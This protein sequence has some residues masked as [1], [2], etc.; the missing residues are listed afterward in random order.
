LFHHQLKINPM[1]TFGVIL[2]CMLSFSTLWGQEKGLIGTWNITSW[3]N[4]GNAGNAKMTEEQLKA[5]NQVTIYYFMEE[6]KFKQTSNMAGSGSNDTYEGTWKTSGKNLVINLSIG[7]QNYDI[8][9]TYE[10][11][12]DI[13]ILTRVS[14]DN[15]MKIINTFR[16][17]Q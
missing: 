4:T 7:G 15:T 8:D 9:Y 6:G 2:L 3:E 1:K 13:L 11:K 10:L 5:N 12:N 16:K 14:P 17:K